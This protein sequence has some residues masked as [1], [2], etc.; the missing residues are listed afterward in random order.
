MRKFLPFLILFLVLIS[1]HSIG[2]SRIL[3]NT[4]S[5]LLRNGQTEIQSYQNMYTEVNFRG[6]DGIEQM[7][8]RRTTYFTS[9][10]Y[11]LFGVS[12]NKRFNIG[13][14]ISFRTVFTDSIISSPLNTFRLQGNNLQRSG[15]TSLGPKVKFLPFKN[16][17][18]LSVQ[19]A[20][21]IPVM[22][23]LETKSNQPWLDWD[24]Y[25]SW[26]QFFYD[27]KTDKFQ[28]FFEVDL[29]A[30]FGKSGSGHGIQ[31]NTPVS[32][33]LS[34]IPN[35]KFILYGMTQYFPTI[36]SENTY[37]I[38]FGIGSKI[39]VSKRLNLEFMFTDFFQSG[40]WGGTGQTFNIG[41]RWIK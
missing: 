2:Q 4:P 18:N 31:L 33:F 17:T 29:L 22:D 26:T 3:T 40:A 24:R 7:G 27:I 1:E 14:D 41:L 28:Y 35:D 15:I 39:Q 16:I 8:N 5:S 34:Y 32:F 11:V 12:N 21:W 25:T 23:S 30:R 20:V 19:S 9:L 6:A 10:N 38:Q 13:M 37:F 36:T